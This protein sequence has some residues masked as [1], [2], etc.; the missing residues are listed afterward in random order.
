MEPSLGAPDGPNRGD[1]DERGLRVAAS[2]LRRMVG[3]V[4]LPF[5]NPA[6]VRRFDRVT[7]IMA[8]GAIATAVTG[9][10]AMEY[11]GELSTGMKFILLAA[12]AL[13]TIAFLGGLA[14]T[15][16]WV[17]RYRDKRGSA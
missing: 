10:L 17:L 11:W 16:W 13:S 15:I 1:S 7:L 8:I 2:L 4:H 14:V 5:E 6:F 3:N 9:V 12:I